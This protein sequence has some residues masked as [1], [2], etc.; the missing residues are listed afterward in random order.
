M[1]TGHEGLFSSECT[2][3]VKVSSFF[4]PE[5]FMSSA[6]LA[7]G[8]TEQ[9][10]VSCLFSLICLRVMVAAA[11]SSLLVASAA[12]CPEQDVFLPCEHVG[13]EV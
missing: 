8:R 9:A 7:V 10:Y 2:R 3:G 6:W 12:G 5:D 1:L 4:N 11:R 13:V